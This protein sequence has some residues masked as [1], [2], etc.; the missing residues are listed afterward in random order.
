MITTTYGSTEGENKV[1]HLGEACFTKVTFFC[2]LIVARP[3][4]PFSPK[5]AKLGAV[6]V[7]ALLEASLATNIA[8]KTNNCFYLSF[9]T[10][11]HVLAL[12]IV[13]S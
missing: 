11:F 3:I 8:D 2:C 5:N 4:T 6:S 12:A 10:D 9:F 1:L 7:I 13:A